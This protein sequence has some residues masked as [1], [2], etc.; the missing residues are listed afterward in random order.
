[1]NEI[2]V[3]EDKQKNK[4]IAYLEEGKLVECYEELANQERIEGNIYVRKSSKSITWNASCFC[5]YWK[6]QK[7]V[8]S[9]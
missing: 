9:H 8:S 6:K 2:I 5:E 3:Y 1:M 7:C 4:N